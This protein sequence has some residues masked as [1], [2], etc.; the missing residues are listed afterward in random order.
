M[1]STKCEIVQ[2]F[3]LKGGSFLA[4]YFNSLFDGERG[5]GGGGL[6]KEIL[7][8]IFSLLKTKIKI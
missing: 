6:G 3:E 1:I 4:N 2:R 5:G 8:N 7:I